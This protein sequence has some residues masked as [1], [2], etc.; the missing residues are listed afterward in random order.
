MQAA[1]HKT[2]CHKALFR[3]IAPIVFPHDRAGKIKFT[4][5]IKRQTS[6]TDI[7]LMFRGVEN[8]FHFLI[9]LTNK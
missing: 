3:V 5:Q 1:T 4:R 6:L 8:N 2:Q 7:S 9:V